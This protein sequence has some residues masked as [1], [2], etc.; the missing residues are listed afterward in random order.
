MAALD[1]FMTQV[2]NRER[3]VTAAELRTYLDGIEFFWTDLIADLR[4]NATDALGI[5]VA[6]ESTIKT[7]VVT[8]IFNRYRDR[9][10]NINRDRARRI[11]EDFELWEPARPK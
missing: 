6:L 8:G 4:A 11:I 2:A 9:E 10:A 1:Y 7:R 5:S 3:V